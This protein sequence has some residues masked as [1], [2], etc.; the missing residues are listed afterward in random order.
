[1]A[2]SIGFYLSAVIAAGSFLSAAAFSWRLHWRPRDTAYQPAPSRI[3]ARIFPHWPAGSGRQ[4]NGLMS[5]LGHKQT[6]G[7][8]R[9]MSALPPKADIRPCDRDACFG[10]IPDSGEQGKTGSV[11]S[12]FRWERTLCGV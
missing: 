2:T 5:A 1:M 6:F 12:T 7:S 10:P 4:R 3:R 9:L 11:R 8:I